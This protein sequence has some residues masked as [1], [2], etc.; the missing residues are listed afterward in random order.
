MIKGNQFTTSL[1]IQ[2]FQLEGKYWVWVCVS[3]GTK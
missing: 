3:E 1:T 2:L